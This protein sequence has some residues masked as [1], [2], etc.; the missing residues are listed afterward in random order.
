M[1]AVSK[2]VLEEEEEGENGGGGVLVVGQQEEEERDPPPLCPASKGCPLSLVG[3]TEPLYACYAASLV[4]RLLGLPSLP[5][6]QIN[7]LVTA[8]A[9]KLSPA[10][11]R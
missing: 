10:Y 2:V 7:S 1:A 5:S 3:R 6:G 8:L 9:D 11:D 4:S